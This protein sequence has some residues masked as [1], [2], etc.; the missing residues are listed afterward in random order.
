MPSTCSK[1]A[2]KNPFL[3]KI[4]LILIKKLWI[5]GLMGFYNYTKFAHLGLGRIDI[6]NR[7]WEIF[8][9]G[10]A[11]R[12]RSNLK[13]VHLVLQQVR[14]AGF[15]SRWLTGW[16]NKVTVWREHGALS[17]NVSRTYIFSIFSVNWPFF[18]QLNYLNYTI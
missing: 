17:C 18:N 9:A 8:R 4:F 7:S 5:A 12:D 14:L 3:L 16:K 10:K 11:S 6:L 15:N 2:N 1:H 13:T